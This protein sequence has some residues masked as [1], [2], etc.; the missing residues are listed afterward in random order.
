MNQEPIQSALK[1]DPAHLNAYSAGLLQG[2]AYRTLNYHLSRSLDGYGLAIPEWKLLALLTERGSLKLA[3]LAELLSVEPP[4]VTKLIDMLEKKKLVTRL[5]DKND[6]RAKLIQSTS[7]G[8][9]IIPKIEVEVKDKM[10]QL[11]VGVSREELLSY[12]KVLQVIVDN[13][14]K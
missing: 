3:Q 14:A 13:G 2:K 8:K 6:R 9:E 12:I 10:R 11:L 4:L 5:N 1:I 7:R